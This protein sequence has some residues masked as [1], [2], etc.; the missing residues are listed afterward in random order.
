MAEGINA[1]KVDLAMVDQRQKE[2]DRIN[3]VIT[4]LKDELSTYEKEHEDA[5]NRL[6]FA[7]SSRSEALSAAMQYR[8][9]LVSYLSTQG[10]VNASAPIQSGSIRSRG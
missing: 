5:V 2:L 10:V 7:I 8:E 4:D 9:T 3:D 6:G 1:P